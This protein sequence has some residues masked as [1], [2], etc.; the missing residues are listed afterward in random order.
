MD[1]N[2]GEIRGVI[3]ALMPPNCQQRPS[4]TNLIR[5]CFF[6]LCC[7]QFKC[8][9]GLINKSAETE[10]KE[11]A[12]GESRNRLLH[13]STAKWLIINFLLCRWHTSIPQHTEA[14]TKIPGEQPAAEEP[15][16]HQIWDGKFWWINY[17]CCRIHRSIRW[18]NVFVDIFSLH[19][20]FY[21]N[22]RVWW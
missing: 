3:F 1:S 7:D 6:R 10:R 5:S 20:Y 14:L 18:L 22:I 12:A 17:C 16:E 15:A 13:Q 21:L 19:R 11:S 9:F 2:D 8:D 4:M